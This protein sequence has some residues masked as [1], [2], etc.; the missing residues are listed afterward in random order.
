VTAV[1]NTGFQAEVIPA[2]AKAPMTT[3]AKKMGAGGGPACCAKG[4]KNT[5][6]KKTGDPQ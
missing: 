2:V 4:K 3:G 1:T 6:A 5:S